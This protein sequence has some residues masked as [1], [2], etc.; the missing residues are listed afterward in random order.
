MIFSLANAVAV[1]MYSI[2]FAETVRDVIKSYGS[3]LINNGMDDIR[4]ISSTTVVILLII[5]FIGTQWE[6]KTQIVLL[7][8]LLTAMVNF[9]IGSLTLPT[10][11]NMSRGYIGWSGKLLIENFFPSYTENE[12]FISIFGVY[13][14]AATGI[15]AGANISGDL[16]NPSK[17][18]PKGTFLSIFITSIVYIVILIIVNVNVMRNANGVIELLTNVTEITPTVMDA[19]SNCSL[20]EDGL[21]K[22]GTLNHYQVVEMM[23]FFGPLIYAGIFAA[24]LSSALASLVSAPKVF[25]ALCSDKLLPGLEYFAVGSGPNNDPKRGFVLSFVIAFSCCMIGELNLIAPIISNFFLSAY[26]LINFA[27]FHADFS[28]S[29]G[30]RPS[31]KFYNKWVSLVGSIFCFIIMMV[32]NWFASALTCVIIFA[33]YLW[34]QKRKPEVNWGSSTQAQD[35]RSAIQSVYRLNLIPDH[36]KTYRPQ[37]LLLSGNPG[38]HSA[39]VDLANTITKSSGMLICGNIITVCYFFLFFFFS[40]RV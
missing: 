20:T 14:P 11:E 34:I 39:F 33:L 22:F 25:Q 9:V 28:K 32:M 27:C 4:I 12:N 30:F 36:A 18:I 29:T 6:S 23:S 24:A 10:K 5:C 8:I 15:L 31:F 17:A 2:G 19:I 37:I 1:A 3:A 13:F 38:T 35:Y 40:S 7:V 26:M 21:C 16:K